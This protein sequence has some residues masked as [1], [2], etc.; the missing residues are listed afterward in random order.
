[1]AAPDTKATPGLGWYP[2]PV[3][4]GR[5]LESTTSSASWWAAPRRPPLALFPL[6]YAFHVAEE[7]WAGESFPVWASRLSGVPFTREEFVVL[8][9]VAFVAMCVAVAVQ[10]RWP[11]A[12]RVVMPALGTIVASNGALHVVASIGSATCSPGVISGA[13]VWLPLGLWTLR[14]A[15]RILPAQHVWNGCGLGL[16]AHGALSAVAFFN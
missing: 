2:R 15:A 3:S 7:A 4:R 14:W 6:T 16:L 11:G 13:M 10:W 9:G 8:N 5:P 12:A 1:M